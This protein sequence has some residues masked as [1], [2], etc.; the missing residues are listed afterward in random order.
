LDDLV[1]DS[2]FFEESVDFVLELELP[3]SGLSES[4]LE[5]VDFLFQ[6]YQLI[7]LFVQDAGIVEAS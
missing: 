5:I 7:F 1:L 6:L 4:L 2:D 3:S